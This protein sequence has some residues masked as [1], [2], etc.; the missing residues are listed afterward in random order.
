MGDCEVFKSL[1]R[2][3]CPLKIEIFVWQ[4]LHGRV[5]VREVL[6]RFGQLG[7][8]NSEC[9]MCGEFEESSDHLFLKCKWAWSLWSCCMGWWNVSSSGPGSMIL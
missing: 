4:V 8:A 1:W 2:S 7:D 6:K 9:P 5:M 3:F